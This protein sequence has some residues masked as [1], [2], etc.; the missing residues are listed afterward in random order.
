M[1]GHQQVVGELFLR[2]RT[3]VHE[4]RLGDVCMAPV[5]VVLDEQS[6]LGVQPDLIF[7]SRL[8]Q[9]DP[10]RLGGVHQPVFPYAKNFVYQESFRVVSTCA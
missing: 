6:A 9:R 5:D 3:H 10:E 4:R 7:I 1:Y 8:G 2:L